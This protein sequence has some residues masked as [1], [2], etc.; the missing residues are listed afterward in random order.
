MR[1]VAP[2]DGS[3]R[4]ICPKFQTSDG[5][6]AT[7]LVAGGILVSLLMA[8][9]KLKGV[10]FSLAGS[11]KSRTGLLNLFPAEYLLLVG[12]RSSLP[13]PKCEKSST[14]SSLDASTQSGPAHRLTTVVP[15]LVCRGA[16]GRR[17]NAH[18]LRDHPDH[19]PHSC[20]DRRHTDMG[21]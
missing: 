14:S 19:N 2:L 20:A 6:R 16:S 1:L 17:E 13:S 10:R 15:G 9:A 21:P 8:V 5:V 3:T 11:D 7:A 12:E 4:S 18:V